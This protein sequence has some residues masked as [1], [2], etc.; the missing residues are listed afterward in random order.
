MTESMRKGRSSVSAVCGYS[1]WVY[2]LLEQGKP[3]PETGQMPESKEL[4]PSHW[5]ASSLLQIQNMHIFCP[6]PIK[7]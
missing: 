6:S 3:P 4:N 2:F 5:S 7:S 1:C